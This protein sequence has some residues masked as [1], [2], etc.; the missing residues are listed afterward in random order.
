MK[1]YLISIG[2]RGFEFRTMYQENTN[3]FWDELSKA[4]YFRI[5]EGIYIPLK[6]AEIEVSYI[7]EV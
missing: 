2:K 5:G 1:K 3:E 4:D 6:K 7:C